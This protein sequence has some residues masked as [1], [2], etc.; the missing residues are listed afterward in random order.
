MQGEQRWPCPCRPPA[1]PARWAPTQ[2]PDEDT[3]CKPS[4]I[5]KTA[6]LS[7]ETDIKTNK[8]CSCQSGYSTG[9]AMIFSRAISSQVP[10]HSQPGWQCPRFD[11]S[12]KVCILHTRCKDRNTGHLAVLCGARLC[13]N[14]SGRSR[15][16]H[17]C[18]VRP[19][20]RC[21]SH[22]SENYHM[23]EWASQRQWAQADSL[24]SAP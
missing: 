18:L 5:T 20:K 3:K 11:E 1:G 8:Q 15:S 14:S 17:K 23:M 2:A 9:K 10:S 19:T 22:V 16:F 12:D 4:Q 24:H 7:Q 13:S 21:F 6:D